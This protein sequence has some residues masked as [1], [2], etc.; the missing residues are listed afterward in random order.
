MKH[1]PAMRA[2]L[3]ALI[4]CSAL[5]LDQITKLV[6]FY[7]V[8]KGDYFPIIDG[9]LGISHVENDAIAYGIGSGNHAFMVVIM[10]VT[11]LL[12]VGIPALAFTVFRKNRPAQ[13]CLAVIEGGAAGNFID[14]LFVRNAQGIAVVRDFVDL[15]RFGFANCN[16]ADFFVTLG[17]VALVIVILFIG[18]QAVFPLK[19]TWR[20]EAKRESGDGEK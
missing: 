11:A 18:P 12:M 19:K 6:S 20:E 10:I 2:L 9:W 14:R 7:F 16:V 13:V 4:A 5:F 17:A 8:P 1:N 15:T 3:Y